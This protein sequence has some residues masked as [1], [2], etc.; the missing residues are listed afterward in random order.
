MKI[1]DA[2][3]QET[4]QVIA[5]SLQTSQF[6]SG[7]ACPVRRL[8][9]AIFEADTSGGEV[10]WRTMTVYKPEYSRIL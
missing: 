10:K 2:K 5:R 8:Y 3:S 7:K 1:H 4:I 9:W 6:V